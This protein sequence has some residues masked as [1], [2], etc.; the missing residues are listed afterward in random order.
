MEIDFA[1]VDGDSEKDMILLVNAPDGGGYVTAEP[2]IIADF[3]KSLGFGMG[4]SD[5]FYHAMSVSQQNSLED[6]LSFI[7]ARYTSGG[8]TAFEM[9][10]ASRI[11]TRDREYPLTRFQSKS[12]LKSMIATGALTFRLP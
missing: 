12:T 8:V 2:F 4:S 3:I 5:D 10:V 1:D 11:F 9:E 6:T 7:G